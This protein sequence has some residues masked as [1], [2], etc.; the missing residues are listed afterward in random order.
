MTYSEK[1]TIYKTPQ[2]YTKRLYS[3]TVVVLLNNELKSVSFVTVCSKLRWHSIS[4][5]WIWYFV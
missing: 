2:Q 5:Y 4:S 1:F 3:A